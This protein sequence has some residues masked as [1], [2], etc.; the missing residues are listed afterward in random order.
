MKYNHS[1][2]T[3]DELLE[4]VLYRDAMLLVIDKP[5]GIAVHQGPGGGPNL[6][7]MFGAL[8]Y[9]LPRPPALVHR[10]DRDTSGCL[11]LGRHRKALRKGGDLF[12]G[13]RAEKT[14]WAICRGAPPQDEGVIDAPLVKKND[15]VN[16]WEMMVQEGGQVAVTGYKVLSR[17]PN[18]SLVAFY[19]KTGRT[20]QIRIHASHV[21]CPL[22]G[23]PRYG[24]L[25]EEERAQ[26]FCLHAKKIVLP[27]YPKKDPIAVEAPL[28]PIWARQ[29]QKL[30]LAL[31]DAAATTAAE[32]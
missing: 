9:G 5:S 24:D 11:V 15:R 17:G 21:G 32:A 30:H 3:P 16:G 20:H 22:L 18:A 23:D 13:G 4:R 27:F 31:P 2:I 1:V 14:Y 12:S 10:L 6:E 25:T 29:A 26:P 28:P 8:T 19:P 7:S